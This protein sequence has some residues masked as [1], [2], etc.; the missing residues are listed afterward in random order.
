MP[1]AEAGALIAETYAEVLS[2]VRPLPTRQREA[3]VLRYYVDLSEAQTA[4][5]MGV[6]QGAVKSHTARALAALRRTMEPRV[7]TSP[8]RRGRL[9]QPSRRGPTGSRWH[10]TRWR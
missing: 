6:S 2:S 10:P 7:M 8:E 3:F 5:V 4:E 1:S 9:R